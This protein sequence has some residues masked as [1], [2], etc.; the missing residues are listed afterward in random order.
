MPVFRIQIVDRGGSADLSLW[1]SADAASDQHFGRIAQQGQR[2]A[3]V[4]VPQNFVMEIF[5]RQDWA[6]V[7]EELA[8][9]LRGLIPKFSE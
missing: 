9:R 7:T 5:E 4:L 2:M 3:E 8:H 1:D 6:L